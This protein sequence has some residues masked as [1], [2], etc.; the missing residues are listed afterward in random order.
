MDHATALLVGVSLIIVIFVLGRLFRTRTTGPYYYAFGDSITRGTGYADLDPSGRDCYLLQM[1]RQYHPDASA[2][3]NM[4]G[5]GKSS[6]WGAAQIGLHLRPGTKIFII[7]FG[8]NDERIDPEVTADNLIAMKDYIEAHGADA[9]LCIP[10]L[11]RE[12]PGI[13][14]SSQE[15]QQRRIAVVEGILASRNVIFVR[16]YDAIDSIPDNGQLDDLAGEYYADDG[17]HPNREGHRR[18]AEM[19]WQ[20]LQAHHAVRLIEDRSG[21]QDSR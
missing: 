6:S 20:H 8:T 1:V 3:H 14:G 11:E 13:P 10:P 4:D 18:M 5:G 15:S 17:I 19:L 7:M 12:Q 2:D 16:M 21:Q 9:V